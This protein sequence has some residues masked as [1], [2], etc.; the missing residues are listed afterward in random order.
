MAT[1]K[2]GAPAVKVTAAAAIAA[3][4]TVIVS[5]FSTVLP[6]LKTFQAEFVTILTFLAGYFVPPS[7]NDTVV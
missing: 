5:T 2:T 3:L 1:M 4:A 7:S 6:E